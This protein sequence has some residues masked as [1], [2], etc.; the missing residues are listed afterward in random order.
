MKGNRWI[1]FLLALVLVV[2][3]LPVQA[4][5][6][7]AIDLD[8]DVSLTVVSRDPDTKA[9]LEG[10]EFRLYRVADTDEW[11]HWTPTEDFSKFVTEAQLNGDP[12]WVKLAD[13]LENAIL[14]TE[15]TPLDTGKTDAK[16]Q[17]KFPCT[18][19]SLKPGLYLVLGVHHSH[20]DFGYKEKPVILMLPHRNQTGADIDS[21]HYSIERISKPEKIQERFPIDI[22]VRKIWKDSGHT[23]ARPTE[24][25]VQLYCDGKPYGDP[26]KLNANNSWK[27]TWEDLE[28]KHKWTVEE[29][30]VPNYDSEVERDGNTF[31]V[32][33]TY[34]PPTPGKP[35]QLPQTG[36]LWW[37]V[38]LL[39]AAGLLL[40][41]V[42]MLRRRGEK[43]DA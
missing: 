37:P 19:D 15:L 22:S 28:A 21:W 27:H 12:D 9:P 36:Q 14:K 24:V 11:A 17:A 40:M 20:G 34:D 18:V 1:S 32:I 41:L 35:P 2:A 8:A 7:N 13:T 26:V 23:N 39:M 5:A 33:N 3:V 16:G 30:D 29:H 38:P 10:A 6:I 31:K 25:T 43:T 4:L 42:G